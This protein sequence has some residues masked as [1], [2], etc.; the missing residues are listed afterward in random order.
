[1]DILFSIQD[2]KQAIDAQKKM[3]KLIDD[4]ETGLVKR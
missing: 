1:M 2:E 4:I 3:V